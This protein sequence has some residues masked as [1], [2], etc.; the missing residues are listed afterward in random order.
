[1]LE[2]ISFR[3]L[4]TPSNIF[5]CFQNCYQKKK[6]QKEKVKAKFRNLNIYNLQSDLESCKLYNNKYMI[7]STEKTNTE[8]F[9]SIAAL[10]L[11]FLRRKVGYFL[12]KQHI[13]RV[14]Y[15]K[16]IN[17]WNAKFSGYFWNL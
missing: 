2:V 6:V 1:M 10:V 13:S 15:C 3:S 11:K 5:N 16:I 17:S 12:K 4:F 9:A 7:A 14:N 8:I